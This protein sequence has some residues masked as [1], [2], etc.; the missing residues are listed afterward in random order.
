MTPPECGKVGCND[1]PRM[2]KAITQLPR[3]GGQSRVC[4][5]DASAGTETRAGDAVTP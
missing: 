5:Q 3:Q 1:A 4:L 2:G